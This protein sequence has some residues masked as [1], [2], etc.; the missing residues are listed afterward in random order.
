MKK[1]GNGRG[2]PTWLTPFWEPW[3]ERC[4]GEPNAGQLARVMGKLKKDHDEAQLIE[5]WTYFLNHTDPQ[6]CS[7][8]AF[9][10]K[11]GHWIKQAKPVWGG[12]H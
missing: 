9:G 2:R 7:P 5:A 6:Y 10:Q 4:G 1:S 3:V 11:A 12:Y 8:S